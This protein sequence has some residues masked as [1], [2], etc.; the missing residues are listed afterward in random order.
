MNTQS[1]KEL[2]K[3][4]MTARSYVKISTVSFKEWMTAT[5]SL[6]NTDI[7]LHKTND[8]CI[9]VVKNKLALS[10]K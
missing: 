4:W 9:R 1:L 6:T 3:Q 7:L 8:G 5:F 10:K 2:L